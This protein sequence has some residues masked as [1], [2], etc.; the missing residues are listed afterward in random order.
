MTNQPFDE[1][2]AGSL[3][4]SKFIVGFLTAYLLGLF[5][6]DKISFDF[7]WAAGIITGLVIAIILFWREEYYRLGLIILVGLILGLTYYHFWDWKENRKTLIYNQQLTTTNC[8][9]DGQP[10]IV[11]DQK[12]TVS[13]Y[14]TKILIQ[15]AKYP[16]YQ[17]GDLLKTT[18]E[19]KNPS[20]IKT[21]DNFNYGQYLLKKGI[22][23]TIEN[24]QKISKIGSGGNFIIK[25]IYKV[26]DAFESS[27]N[28]VLAEPYAA[29]QAGLILGAKTNIPDSLMSE[30][31]RTG[32]THIVAVSGYNVTI[33]IMVLALLLA[34]YSRRL[35]FY[36][37]ILGIIFFVILTGAVSSVL[38]AG[39]LTGLVL[40]ARF[41]GRRPYYPILLL[42]VAFSMLLFNP[43][44]LKN[45]VSFQLSFL[46]FVGL[47]YI[48][49]KISEQKYVS[50]LP[51]IIKTAFS[52]TMGAQIGVLPILL[53][54][55]GILSL[56]APLANILI[57]P[58]VPTSMLLGFVAG[59]G[60]M[61]YLELGRLFGLVAWIVLK[62]ILVVVEWLAK[63]PWAAIALKTSDW[64]WIP[65]YY[66]VIL[67]ICYP[68]LRGVS[69]KSNHQNDREQEE[70]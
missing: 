67:L 31:N 35:S 2:R 26:G 68:K 34:R 28:R 56:V 10:K 4:K 42:L 60:G 22:R 29:F 27:L 24:P 52:E 37:S 17:Y 59:L 65:I 38:R 61:I 3:G 62:Y 55:F 70:F 33:V 23:G 13:C 1:L 46:A 39:I 11:D 25:G 48:A 18:G 40:L 54:N 66:L 21:Q 14:N 44:A 41:I 20:E 64:W 53:F 58:L 15:T 9:V 57:L 43:Y 12:I 50:K 36:G 5:F 51:E 49:P 45:D 6:G 47:I 30:F 63:V 16:K 8:Q 7:G 32:T 19:I 69:Q